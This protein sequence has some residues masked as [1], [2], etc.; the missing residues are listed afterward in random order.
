MKT[1]RKLASLVVTFG[2]LLV[3][4]TSAQARPTYFQAMKT[5][6]GIADDSNLDACYVCH[7][8]YTGTST[9]NPFGYAVQQYLYTGKSIQESL[10]LVEDLD[11]DG[12]GFTN[13]EELTIELT[14]P[15]FSCANFEDAVGAPLG[16]DSFVTPGIDTCRDPIE[17]HTAPS[18]F[19]FI[20]DA[21][22][23]DSL[24]VQIWNLG[25]EDPLVIDSVDLTNIGNTALSL[26]H[27]LILPVSIATDE[28]VTIELQFAPSS[29]LATSATLEIASN[30]P[31]DALLALPVNAL[32]TVRPL[33]PLSERLACRDVIQKRLASYGKTQLRE[34]TK[35][36]T[37]E[38]LG[39][40]CQEARRDQKIARAEAK[41]ASFVGGSKDK[42]CIGTGMTAARLDMPVTCGGGC[43]AL[44]LTGIASIRSCALCRQ[45]EARDALLLAAFGTTPPD[46]PF[47][48]SGRDAAKCVKKI[49]KAMAKVV[50]A[51]Q[52]ELAA[53]ASEKLASGGDRED[54]TAET[55]ERIGKLRAK[56]DAA[57]AACSDIEGLAG[58]AFGDD[59]D[60]LCAGDAA[61]AIGQN[62]AD[63]VWV[64]Y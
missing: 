55:A 44:S 30:D 8:R 13:I 47:A 41:L 62:L 48:T 18:T 38:A 31:N 32:G 28:F 42:E 10:T 56:V 23:V 26:V 21:N 53:C 3:G 49:G 12:D 39:F 17:I 9:R 50:P 54:C 64:E 61:V 60:P 20:T 40:R 58:C 37:S 1:L 43:S 6:F 25:H 14:L 4:A 27:D 51:I 5:H 45:N 19:G 29:T 63:T 59:A 36:F 52:K 16:F 24:E 35:C 33:N 2:M 34:W 11:S 22:T 15:G 7:L 57:V 46:L